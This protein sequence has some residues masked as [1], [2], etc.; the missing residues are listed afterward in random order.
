MKQ[1]LLN[2]L[3]QRQLAAHA[4]ESR[5]E[6]DGKRQVGIA[7]W[8]R[9]TELDPGGLRSGSYDSRDTDEGRAIYA[10]PADIDWSLIS[11]YE[12]LVGVDQR[13][14]DCAHATRMG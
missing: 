2:R 1:V 6:H 10:G 7:A 12:A 4:I 11:R 9:T 5:G 3:R 14:Q 13:S 8:I